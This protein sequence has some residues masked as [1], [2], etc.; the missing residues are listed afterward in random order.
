MLSKS[1][2]YTFRNFSTMIV[3]EVVML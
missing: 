1:S 3:S 2:I